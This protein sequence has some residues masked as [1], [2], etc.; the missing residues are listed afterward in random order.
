MKDVLERLKHLNYLYPK[1]VKL[2]SQNKEGIIKL[3][4]GIGR[5]PGEFDPDLLEFLRLTNGASIL[6][7]CF[8]GFKNKMLGYDIDEYM[9][10]FWHENNRYALTALPFMRDTQKEHFCLWM[11]KGEAFQSVVYIDMNVDESPTPIASNFLR[12][13][14]TFV[15]DVKDTLLT[16]EK[17]YISKTQWPLSLEHWTKNDQSLLKTIEIFSKKSF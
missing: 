5:I 2:Y 9:L 1:D 10:D 16:T 4:K 7:Y 6:D 15:E 8:L 3:M 17:L 13:M 14:D 11:E 12:F